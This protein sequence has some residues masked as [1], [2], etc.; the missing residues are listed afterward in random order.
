MTTLLVLGLPNFNIPFDV[1]TDASTIAMG[2]FYLKKATHLLILAR[3]WELRCVSVP[4]TKKK[5]MLSPGQYK[6]GDNIC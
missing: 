2:G 6:S 5:C 4:L 3:R 1:T